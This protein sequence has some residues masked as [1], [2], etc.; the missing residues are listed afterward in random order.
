MSARLAAHCRLLALETNTNT[1]LILLSMEND[2]AFGLW[3]PLGQRGSSTF[4]SRLAP[5]IAVLAAGSRDVPQ[6]LAHGK[7]WALARPGPGTGRLS[8]SQTVA[9]D[10]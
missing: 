9:H 7:H 3:S 6:A 8:H 5:L 2:P 10:S 1:R 4:S